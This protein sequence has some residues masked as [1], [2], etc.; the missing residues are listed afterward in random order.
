M[1]AIANKKRHTKTQASLDRKGRLHNLKNTFSLTKNLKLQG[2]ETLLI[3]DDITTTGSTIN[4]LAKCIKNHYP[5][6][7]VR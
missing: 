7:K 1:I 2:N 4:E 6:T 3:I 5:N